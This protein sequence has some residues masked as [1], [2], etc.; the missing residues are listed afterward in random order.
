MADTEKTNGKLRII[1]YLNTII[2]TIIAIASGLLFAKMNE[3]TDVQQLFSQEIVRLKTVQEINVKAVESLDQRVTTLE[4]NY[5]DYI[6]TWVDQNYIRKP[7][8]IK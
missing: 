1:E 2:L 6:K 4:L 3:V 7:Q 5:L 8:A